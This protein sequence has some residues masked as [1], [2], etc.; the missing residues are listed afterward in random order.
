M[1]ENLPYGIVPLDKEGPELRHVELVE[2]L[3][4][5]LQYLA[6]RQQSDMTYTGVKIKE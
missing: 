1:L 2:L 3:T 4:N 6:L 5:S